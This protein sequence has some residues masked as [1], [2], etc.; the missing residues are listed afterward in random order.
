MILD[1][2]YQIHPERVMTV[3]WYGDELL[4]DLQLYELDDD[5]HEEFWVLNPE[6]DIQKAYR[7]DLKYYIEQL[8]DTRK[9]IVV[10]YKDNWIAKI[11]KQGWYPYHGYETLEIVKPQVVWTKNPDLDKLIKFEN[12]PFG[13]FEPDRWDRDYKLIWFLDPRVNPLEEKI[14]AM[15]CEPIGKE[16][17]GTKDMGY[18]MPLIDIKINS[19]LPELNLD[20]NNYYPPY[21]E[22]D[23][24][25]V[26]QLESNHLTEKQLWVMKYIPAWRKNKGWKWTGVIPLELVGDYNPVWK[27]NPKLDKLMT[28]DNDPINSYQ[29][30]LW[31]RDY[32][33]IWY[34]DPRVNPLEEKIWA[35]T[36]EPKG[37]TAKGVK[38]MGY[39]MPALDVEYNEYLPELN[40]D[41][42][43][44]YP[45][46][47]QLKYEHAYELDPIHKLEEKMWAIK[48]SPKYR[49]SAGWKWAGKVS[50]LMEIDYNPDLGK[51]NYDL[52]YVIPWYDFDF[53]HIW[54]LDNIHLVHGEHEEIWAFKIR[55][56]KRPNGAKIV[57]YISPSIKTKVNPEIKGLK[58]DINYIVPWHDL[59]YE[60]VWMLDQECY[61]GHEPIWA[62]KQVL[63][64]EVIGSKELGEITPEQKLIFNPALKNLYIEIDYKIPYHDRQYEHVWYT[65]LDGEL[66]WS[67]KLTAVSKPKGVKDM[68]R[69]EP[70]IPK[71]LDVVFISYF[72]PNAEQNW[73]RVLE[74]APHAKR[75]DG[76][77][78][79]FN[80]HRAAAELAETD[81]FY[82]VDGDA[83]L[84]D[85]WTFDFQPTLFDRDCAFIWQSQNPINGLVYGYAGVK[86]F[87]KSLILKS[88][89]WTTLDYSTTV[90]PKLK[91]MDRVSNIAAFD[92]DEFSVWKSAFRE[93]TKL[94]YNLK[95]NPESQEDRQRL[96]TWLSKGEETE[97]GY[98]AIDAANRAIE[99]VEQMTDYSELL[100]INNRNWLI[101]YYETIN[102]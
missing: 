92:T 86:L 57:D 61:P 63:A 31:D 58:F 11:F 52:D 99:F 69:V 100:Q 5:E 76:V 85:N 23:Y 56:S 20:I 36:C 98:A 87:S 17:K 91:I 48:I 38:D 75:V 79:I 6:Y 35:L 16:I 27:K 84:V 19:K 101:E 62:V 7:T 102:S 49:E 67:A 72:E 95:L 55:L 14:W 90:M 89:K 64:E 15:T 37:K 78:G 2:L 66:V 10:K 96:D 24:E 51:L 45:P 9:C 50:P 83:W 88:K 60:H 77:M 82:V 29:P 22:L 3:E 65:E 32:K 97:F 70:I 8:P 71:D 12:D 43:T 21:W 44:L 1:E 73:K 13:E 54:M 4:Y 33:L 34:L 93:C 47:W 26:Y 74:K 59:D 41:I 25:H 18:V 42:D 68:G 28:F 46:Y 53:E 40:I 39:V 81:M 94:A 30:D 80:A